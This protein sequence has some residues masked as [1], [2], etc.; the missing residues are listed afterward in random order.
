MTQLWP[1]GGPRP[2]DADPACIHWNAWAIQYI[3]ALEIPRANEIAKPLL[4]VGD[5]WDSSGAKEL[6]EH[7]PSDRNTEHDDVQLSLNEESV[8]C[9]ERARLA[10]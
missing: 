5:Q 8:S 2:K 9:F 1:L 7:L 3:L 6:C 10:S 4:R